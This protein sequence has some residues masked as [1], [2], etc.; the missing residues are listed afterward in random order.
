MNATITLHKRTD[1]TIEAPAYGEHLSMSEIERLAGQMGS[2][3]FEPD[4]MRFFRSRVDWHVWPGADGWYFVTSE[5]HKGFDGT[6]RPRL[7]SVRRFHYETPANDQ[8]GEFSGV[9][10]DTV[11]EF[12]AYPTLTR[13]RTAARKAAEASK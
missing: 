6:M 11:G 9:D 2:H 13:A 10:F 3:Y 5:Q 8:M 1:Y 7:Y 12:Q 4:T